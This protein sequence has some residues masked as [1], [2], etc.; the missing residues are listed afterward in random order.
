MKALLRL[1]NEYITI[2]LHISQKMIDKI[3]IF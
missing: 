1:T 2:I 3:A